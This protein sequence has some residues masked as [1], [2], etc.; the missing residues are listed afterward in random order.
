MSDNDHADIV[1]G[2]CSKKLGEHHNLLESRPNQELQKFKTGL[3]KEK[4][5]VRFR[6]LN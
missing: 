4:R 6:S 1:E 5:N 2:D 3:K